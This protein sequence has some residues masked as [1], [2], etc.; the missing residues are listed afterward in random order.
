MSISQKRE[1]HCGW[2]L[3]EAVKLLS[4]FSRNFFF[5]FSECA[6]GLG[7]PSEIERELSAG[8]KWGWNSQVTGR[9][10]RGII[11]TCIKRLEMLSYIYTYIDVCRLQFLEAHPSFAY[12]I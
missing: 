7:N 6:Y 11:P 4:Q 10:L 8:K 3:C 2:I 12:T 1:D 9:E 5:L